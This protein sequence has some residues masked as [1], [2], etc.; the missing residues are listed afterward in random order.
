LKDSHEDWDSDTLFYVLTACTLDGGD[1]GKPMEQK[2]KIGLI[3]AIIGLFMCIF[4]RFSMT[5]L[6]NELHFEEKRL[7]MALVSIEDYSITGSI[8]RDLF[9]R[10]LR[11][12]EFYQAATRG[13]KINSKSSIN[14]NTDEVED[15]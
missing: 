2:R 3:V 12:T 4:F 9:Q 7:D 10:I 15:Q 11:Q 6:Q 1:T 13:D 14:Q 5:Y 8:D